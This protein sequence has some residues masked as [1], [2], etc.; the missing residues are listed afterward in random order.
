MS[1]TKRMATSAMI[2]ALMLST[3]ITACQAV[4]SHTLPAAR[5]HVHAAE[6][7][8]VHGML[9]VG[10]AN[11]YVSHLPMF[12]APHNAQA[13]AAVTMA[14]KAGDIRARLAQDRART[15][16][17]VYTLVPDPSPLRP[18]FTTGTTYPATLYRGHFERGGSPV[19]AKLQV[20]CS[21]VVHFRTFT[22]LAGSGLQPKWLL[23]G[24]PKEAFAAHWISAP[25]D[26]DQVVR[27]K[28]PA[29]IDAAF[30]AKGG[31]AA[32]MAALPL[33]AGAAL[34]ASPDPA[35]TPAGTAPWPVRVEAAIYAETGDLAH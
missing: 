24:T 17:T 25:P 20:T 29:A 13:I 27:L 22:P 26:L 2:S 3:L 33:T 32:S 28:V 5:A 8:S 12:H 1:R 16:E 14:D 18:L 10:S 35:A 34:L 21:R 15:G 31:T 11:L 9:V 6:A 23:F 4:M 19:F 7:P 30:L